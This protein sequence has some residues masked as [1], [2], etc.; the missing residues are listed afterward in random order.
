[1]LLN[2]C[3]V[4]KKKKHTQKNNNPPN[5]T[6]LYASVCFK[7][8]AWDALK[9]LSSSGSHSCDRWSLWNTGLCLLLMS[10]RFE[11]GATFQARQRP[12]CVFSLNGKKRERRPEDHEDLCHLYIL[13]IVLWKVKAGNLVQQ[14]LRMSFPCRYLKY[15]HCSRSESPLYSFS[16]FAAVL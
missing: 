2:P 3:R 16:Y 11:N 9:V 14:V 12:S 8:Q 15:S 5:M 6:S 10:G 4:K 7:K 1:M 13:E